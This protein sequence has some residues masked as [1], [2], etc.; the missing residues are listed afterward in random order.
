MKKKILLKASLFLMLLISNFLFGIIYAQE[1]EVQGELKV[2]QM[3]ANENGDKLVIRNSDGTLGTRNVSSLPPPPPEIDTLRNLASD[4]ELANHLCNCPNLPPFLIQ[5][6]L[7]SGYTEEDLLNAGVSYVDISKAQ[8]TCGDTLVDN[9]DGRLYTT[10]RIG[11]QCW[12]TENLDIGTMIDGSN[13]QTDNSI[14]EKYCYDDEI[15]NCATYGGLYQWDEMMQYSTLESTQGVCPV[16]WHLP[17]DDEYKTLEIHLGMTMAQADAS[18]NRGTDQGSKL[19]GNEPL[20][21]DDL[22][23]QNDAFDMS[24]FAALP[25]GHR[26]DNLSFNALSESAFF[27]SSSLAT[28][29]DPLAR[30]ILYNAADVIRGTTGKSLGN[31]VR[32]VQD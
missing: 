27:W 18:G 22:L 1:V 26:I 17:S 4:Y 21:T 19:A 25:G 5:N 31:S 24:G 10:L 14:I 12:M 28:V 13:N 8:F 7:E 9:R 20:W 3:N 30:L 29:S 11:G 23:D 16:G 6:L 15:S 32:C 2:T